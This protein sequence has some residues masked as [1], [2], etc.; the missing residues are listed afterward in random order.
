MKFTL[1][2][3]SMLRRLG[4]SVVVGAITILSMQGAVLTQALAQN[5]GEV[6]GARQSRPIALVGGTIHPV[7]GP[8]IE[9]GT[10]VFEDGVITAIGPR[11]R[12][13]ENA[14]E[15]DISGRH[16][17]PGLFESHSQLGLTEWA[18][19]RATQDG[20]E[21][22]MLNPN[23][24]ARAAVNPDSDL[25]AVT[26]ANGVLLALSAP[27]G[28]LVSGRG[29]VLQLDG[30]TNDDLTL[31]AAAGLFIT[32]PRIAPPITLEGS[33]APSRGRG[34][35]GNSSAS[36]ANPLEPLE[37]LFDDARAY[38]SAVDSGDP[39]QGIDLRLESMRPV[40]DREIP[41][42][43][44][45]DGL[46]EIESAVTFAVEQNVRLVIFGGYD[47]PLAAALL[48]KHEV[49]VI[50][51]AVHR[52]PRRRHDAYDAAYTLPARLAEAGIDF[53]ISGSDRAET[54]NTRNLAYHAGTAVAYGLS[55]DEA[56]H[57]ITLAPARIFGVDDRVG[58]L[59]VGKDATLIITDGSPLETQ[60]NVEWA[61]VQ[62]RSVQLTS[63]HTRLYE[64]YLEKY[65][66]LQEEGE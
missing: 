23:V 7:S 10:I 37:K 12:V 40:L 11:V 50:V 39:N 15:V 57:S 4:V 55:E 66:Q 41:I 43:V 22:G 53:S 64:K 44:A 46:A 47:A 9:R 18:A 65:R 26:R 16:V 3:S 28:G 51:S 61:F 1:S 8:V 6:P 32:W 27:S 36:G 62:G 63:R 38:V 24:E 29:S 19:V 54:Y 52:L 17:Y 25:I 14:R 13:P 48:T 58:S 2:P 42:V 31:E 34:R 30:W 49:P 5:T 60:T 59:E 21:S 45:A 56:I 35:G 33:A 20:S